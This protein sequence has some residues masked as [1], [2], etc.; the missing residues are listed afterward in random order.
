MH[1]RV[2]ILIRAEQ[3][4]LDGISQFHVNVG[5]PGNKLRTLV[6][7]FGML[8]IQKRVIFANKKDVV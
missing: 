5:E 1:N 7:I 4:T 8:P 2:R 3:L 6:D